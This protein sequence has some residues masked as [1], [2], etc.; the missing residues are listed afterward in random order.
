MF[1]IITYGVNRSDRGHLPYFVTA[2]WHP[3]QQISNLWYEEELFA[4][5]LPTDL[6]RFSEGL[7]GSAEAA[8]Q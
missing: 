4:P 2:F 8:L 1:A 5:P 6:L 3:K 7:R